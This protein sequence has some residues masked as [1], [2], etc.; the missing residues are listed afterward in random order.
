MARVTATAT[1]TAMADGNATERAGVMIDGDHNGNG[2]R[3]RQWT[4]ASAS[5][6]VMELATMTEMAMA[7]AMATATARVMMMKAGLLLHVPAMCSAM[8][9][10]TPCLHPHGHKGKCIHQRCVMG[11]TLLRVLVPDSSP[12][13]VFLFIIY[14]YCS[15]Y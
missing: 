15:V 10:V 2:R 12:W 9:G 5:A 1:A 4:T 3:Q 6:M 14:N 7:I 13:I 11:V 8:A